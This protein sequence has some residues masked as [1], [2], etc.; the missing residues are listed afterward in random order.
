M[1]ET[2]FSNLRRNLAN[3]RAGKRIRNKG[4]GPFFLDLPT[5]PIMLNKLM[6]D[7]ACD[8]FFRSRGML[9]KDSINSW[10]RRDQTDPR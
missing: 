8:K 9:Q 6:I 2:S 3:R 7:S 10:T 5:Q 1:I 4:Q